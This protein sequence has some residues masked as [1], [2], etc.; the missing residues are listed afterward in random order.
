MT[1]IFSFWML[2]L[3]VA[4]ACGNG[5]VVVCHVVG[6]KLEWANYEMTVTGKLGY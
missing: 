2:T 4:G 3:Q 1:E 6:R 5:H